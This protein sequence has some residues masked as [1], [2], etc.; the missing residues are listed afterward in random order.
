MLATRPK[1]RHYPFLARRSHAERGRLAITVE[2]ALREAILNL[3]LQP[4]TMLDKQVI[5]ERL[6]VSRSPVVAAIARLAEEGLLEVLPQRGTRVTRIALADIRQQL[7]IR[8]ALEAEAAGAIAESVADAV[9]DA[10]DA[11][12]EAQQRAVEAQDERGFHALDLQFHEILLDALNL[13]R[14][15]AVVGSARNALD[16]ARRLMATPSR[17]RGTLAEHVRVVKALRKRDAQAAAEA[18]RAHLD[19][20]AK[21]LHR[22]ARARPDLFDGAQA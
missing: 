18:M 4:G 14:V 22:F 11:N 17:I 12:L 2:T 16:R 1:G 15:K 9:L 19:A 7:F 3:D 21:E 20:V 10:L 13:P 5:C 8:R 6:H